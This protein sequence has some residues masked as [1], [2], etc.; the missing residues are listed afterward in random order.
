MSTKYVLPTIVSRVL[1]KGGH[2]HGVS[3]PNL[4]LCFLR[5]FI[6]GL[7]YRD[8]FKYI[9]FIFLY[10]PFFAIKLLFLNEILLSKP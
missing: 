2:M 9:L 6:W 1:G 10:I 5:K 8:P 4:G 3:V 7:K